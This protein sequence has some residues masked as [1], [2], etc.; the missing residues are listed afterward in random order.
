MRAYCKTDSRKV[1]SAD[2]AVITEKHE[3]LI[4]M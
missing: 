1:Y 2:N 4:Y 3:S